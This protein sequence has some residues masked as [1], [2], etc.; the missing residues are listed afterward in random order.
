MI[1]KHALIFSLFFTFHVFFSVVA[2]AQEDV[3]Q[4]GLPEGAIR[5]IGKGTISEIVYSPDGQRLAVASTVGI[6]IYDVHTTQPLNLLTGHSDSVKS[7][8]FSPD[9]STIA[10]GGRFDDSTVRLWDVKT[11]KNIK[12]LKGHTNGVECVSFSP[13]GNTKSQPEVRVGLG[14]APFIYGTQIQ[15]EISTHSQ[16]IQVWSVV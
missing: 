10:S 6:W 13:D 14:T 8:S 5:R 9:G 12:T 1:K 7:V 16:D 11:G 2:S 15:A 4:W 3:Q